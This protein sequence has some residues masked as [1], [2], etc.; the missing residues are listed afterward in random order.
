MRTPRR[1]TAILLTGAVA[2]ASGAYAIGTQVGGGS[3]AAGDSD[4]GPRHFGPGEPFDDLA[5]AL[6][7]EGNELRD[8][9]ADFRRQHASGQ[10]DAFAAA[11]ADAL[12]KSTEEVERALEERRDAGRTE[13][14]RRLAAALELDP[15]KVEAALEKVFDSAQRDGVHRPGDF[16]DDL[17][18]E[19]G[20]SADKLENAL[21]QVRPPDRRH[22]CGGPGDR[23]PALSGLA[24]ALDVTPAELRAALRQIWEDGPAEQSELAEFLA[25]RFNLS[26]DE[27]EEALDDALPP[28]P[29]PGLRG[30]PGP[31]FGPPGPPGSPG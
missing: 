24:R 8:A 25:K 6:G 30:G 22:V 15:D 21:R 9:L 10:R 20:V 4:A 19:L 16:I 13:F 31:G 2:L 11:L 18:G 23:G 7:V 3:A 1:T 5:D 17:A 29:G 27:V 12:G 28:R 14:A 26:V